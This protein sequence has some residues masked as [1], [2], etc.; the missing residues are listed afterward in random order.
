M[1]TF[2]VPVREEVSAASQQSFDTLKKVLGMVPNLYATMAYSDNA[3]SKFLTFQNAPTSLSNKEKEAVNLIVSQI[4]GCKY[5]LSAH[6]MLGKMNGFTDEEIILIR[7]GGSSIPKINAL[8]QMAKDV[9][10]NKGHVT[11]EKLDA[12]FEAGYTKGNLVDLILLV[13]D[14]TIM[15]Y[16]HNL[17]DIAIDFPLA[18]EL[19]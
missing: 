13:G 19:N 9:T 12:F 8:V 18:P 3:L 16:L 7:K 4:N 15:N 17:T 10:E 2:K 1:T 5:C 11:P 6:T 14:K